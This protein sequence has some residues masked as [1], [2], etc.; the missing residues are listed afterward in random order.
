MTDTM[1]FG[2]S[3]ETG[4][5]PAS[6]E[7]SPQVSPHEGEVSP[8]VS[9]HEGEVSPHEGEDGKGERISIKLPASMRPILDMLR[10]GNER[11]ATLVKRIIESVPTLHN[12]IADLEEEHKHLQTQFD[13]VRQS[14]SERESKLLAI[15]DTLKHEQEAGCTAVAPTAEI[16]DTS[17]VR[18][19][20][21]D[22]RDICGDDAECGK[23]IS[24]MLDIKSHFASKA[25]DQAHD[26]EQKRLDREQKERDRKFKAEQA[27]KERKHRIELALAKKGGF[28]KDFL[29]DV[30]FIGGRSPKRPKEELKKQQRRAKARSDEED[31]GEN[32]R[33]TMT[34]G[35]IGEGEED[36]DMED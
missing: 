1:E 33:N 15:I 27:E 36:I 32:L 34:E 2:T 12:R 26:A 14:A 19:I 22:T 7:V 20:V 21:L 18:D 13:A 6:G 23:I 3:P 31:G 28:K 8:Q 24:K 30:V 17:V 16:L 9:P 25:M 35:Y 5:K 4:A 29:E 11:N 10:Q